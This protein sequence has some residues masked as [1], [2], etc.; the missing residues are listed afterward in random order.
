MLTLRYILNQIYHHVSW[1]YRM[2]SGRTFWDELCY[3]YNQGVGEA[4]RFQKVWDTMEKFIDSQRFCDVQH[5]LK[6]QARDAVCWRDA[7]LLYFQ[8]FSK[9][10]IPYELERPIHELKEMMNYKLEITNF[11]CPP[12]GFTQ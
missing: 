11:E 2:K 1:N 10:P 5:R 7:C 8:Q 9:Q 3:A 12:S 6:I 4:R